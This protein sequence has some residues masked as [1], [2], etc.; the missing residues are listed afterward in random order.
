MHGNIDTT[1][2]DTKRVE[3]PYRAARLSLQ[4][5]VAQTYLSLRTLDTE[6]ALLS[7]MLVNHEEVLKPARRRFNTGDIGELNVT[8]V[9]AEPTA[10][11]SDRIG[12]QHRHAMLGYV[13]ATP[14]SKA[15]ADFTTGVDPL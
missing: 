8:R 6:E 7:R 1:G 12:V 11:R 3:A 14:L 5:D 2:V 15:S 10:A 4:T 13:L 9:D